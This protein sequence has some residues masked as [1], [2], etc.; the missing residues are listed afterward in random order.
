MDL[1]NTSLR[2]KEDY[3]KL[4]IVQET[5]KDENG[6]FAEKQFNEWHNAALH[7]YNDMAIKDYQKEFVDTLKAGKHDIFANPA[8]RE[9]DPGFQLVKI[10]NPYR[11]KHSMEVLGQS[12]ERQSSIDEIAQTRKILTNPTDVY[13]E[14]GNA[15]WSLAIWDESP[16]DE[17]FTNDFFDTRVLA[18]YDTDGVHKDPITGEMV[19]HQKGDFRLNEEGTFYYESLDGRNVTGRRVLNKMN[20]LTVDGSAWN[21]YDFFDSDDLEQKSFTGS[22]MRNLALVGT[23]FIPYVG[24]WIAG[25]SVA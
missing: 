8:K 20:T 22:V 24:P 5:F 3:A 11:I 13:D 15:D 14:E 2:N 25:L 17:H 10:Q 21:K 12:G 7:L 23:M 6:N 1:E 18:Q 16:N 4:D 9:M 19:Q